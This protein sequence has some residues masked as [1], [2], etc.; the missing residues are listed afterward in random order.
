[1]VGGTGRADSRSICH[2]A[3]FF[4]FLTGRTSFFKAIYER[5]G[6]KHRAEAG[7][8]LF[9]KYGAAVLKLHR[10]A[11]YLEST[12]LSVYPFANDFR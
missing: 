11:E 10:T 9:S 3:D 12:G 5:L 6:R 7:K 4:S 1:M 8:K 2:N